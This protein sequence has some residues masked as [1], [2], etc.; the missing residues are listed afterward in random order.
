[1][2]RSPLDAHADDALN[3]VYVKGPMEMVK[4]RVAAQRELQTGRRAL[5][6]GIPAI[7][8]VIKTVWPGKMMTIVAR[9]SSG[10]TSMMV[11]LAR[12][13]C[14]RLM[15]D[16][17][18]GYVLFVSLEEDENDIHAAITGGASTIQ[19]LGGGV[20]WA[21]EERKTESSIVWPIWLSGYEPG[22]LA[23]E[24]EG[25]PRLSI[26]QVYREI[27]AVEKRDHGRPSVIFVDYLQI[28]ETEGGGFASEG[29]NNAVGH[30]LLTLRKIAKRVGCPIVVGVQAKES[31]DAKRPP[32]PQLNDAFYSSEVGHAS[33]VMVSLY[34]PDR[35]TPD[36]HGGSVT[37]RGATRDVNER[38][39]WVQLL[40]QRKYI[41]RAAWLVEFDPPAQTFQAFP[42]P[43]IHSEADGQP[44]S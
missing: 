39:M 18:G 10:K 15:A 27:V 28:V 32:V 19:M 42:S 38:L 33:D 4:A 3:Q 20:D 11:H 29:R 22:E 31:V 24:V 6:F 25:L 35:Y 14:Q 26:E 9:P 12:V 23:P 37:L 7:D 2:T 34:Y 16:K 40:K 21:A 17:S 44:W 36:V 5:S 43:R 1:M 13:E 41:G 8:E 30:A